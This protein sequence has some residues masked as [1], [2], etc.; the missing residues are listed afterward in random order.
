[1]LI[2]L[3]GLPGVG[4]STI[5]RRLAGRLGLAL[6]D[7]DSL[8]EARLGEAIAPFFE[9]EGEAAFRDHETIVLGEALGGDDAVVATGGGVVVREANRRL[10]RER[11]VCVYLHAH[12]Q[13]LFARLRRNTRRPLLRVADPQARIVEL[14]SERDPLYRE[15][16]S[17]VVETEGRGSSAIIALIEAAIQA[18]R[19]SRAVAQRTSEIRS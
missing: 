7:C 3:V 16:A 4:K 1:V 10:L 9:R 18:L 8:V 6:L 13:A 12:P 15:C 19:D 2:S 14:A 11:T 5:G 17:V